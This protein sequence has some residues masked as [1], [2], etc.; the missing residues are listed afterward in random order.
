MLLPRGPTLE[1]TSRPEFSYAEKDSPMRWKFCSLHTID[2]CER[3]GRCITY[4]VLKHTHSMY[5]RRSW[6]AGCGYR[7]RRRSGSRTLNRAILVSMFN[8]PSSQCRAVI[9]FQNG[10]G[11]AS[12]IALASVPVEPSQELRIL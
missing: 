4:F 11:L 8:L 12:H 5:N 2:Q 7:S 9:L 3:L 6:G 10:S 1:N